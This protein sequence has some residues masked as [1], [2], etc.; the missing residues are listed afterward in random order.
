MEFGLFIQGYVPQ[1]RLDAEYRQLEVL[2]RELGEAG[3]PALARFLTLRA[4]GDTPLLLVDLL[5]E[6]VVGTR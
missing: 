1:A 2:A 4:G 3:Y 5:G 6:E